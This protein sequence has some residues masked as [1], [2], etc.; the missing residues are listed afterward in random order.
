VVWCGVVWCG[1]VWCGVEVS[2]GRYEV[3]CIQ[4]FI[5]A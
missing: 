2:C 3:D 4:D 1:V 5:A